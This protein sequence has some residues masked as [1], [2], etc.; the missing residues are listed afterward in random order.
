M[1]KW[2][3]LSLL[4]ILA[5]L[6]IALFGPR[7]VFLRS[8][9]KLVI[10]ATE[11]AGAPWSERVI[12]ISAGGSNLFGVWKDFF[13]GPMFIYSFHDAQRFLVVYDADI[14]VLAF[15]VD[16]RSSATNASNQ[17]PWPPDEY[18]RKALEQGATNVVIKSKGVVRLPDYE[19]V[20][21]VVSN[22]TAWTPKQFKAASF[23]V[24]DL[25]FCR[26]HMSDKRFILKAIDPKRHSL[27]PT[28]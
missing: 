24:L 25:G 23:P 2:L 21:E 12:A 26:F 14:S 4:L 16:Q 1:L 27:W 10:R 18:T 11:P 3:L 20:Q 8:D 15:V 6:A 19:E 28:E 22:V 7:T 5:L 9:A 17:V 13:D